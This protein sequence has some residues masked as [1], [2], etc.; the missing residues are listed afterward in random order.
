MVPVCSGVGG[1]R[2]RAAQPVDHFLHESYAG[3][4]D[5]VDYL[6]T[7]RTALRQ[8]EAQQS[9]ELLGPAAV[10]VPVVYRGDRVDPHSE[11][12]ASE[13]GVSGHLAYG[14]TLRVQLPVAL[15]HSRFVG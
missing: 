7:S 3:D 6:D 15:G 10:V 9:G 4:V 5:H 11:S 2:S 14:H 1:H 8:R 13:L 12:S